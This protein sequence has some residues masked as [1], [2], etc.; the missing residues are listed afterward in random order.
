MRN[1][2]KPLA[3]IIILV[4]A[5]VT[6]AIYTSVEA[7]ESTSVKTV[8]IGVDGMTCEMCAASLE[9]ELKATKGVIDA[10]VSFKK[11]NAWIKYNE[12]QVTVSQL[13]QVI[14]DAGFKPVKKIIN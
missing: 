13:R 12:R 4:L 7:S 2:N 1:K 3:L 10:R 9:P 5:V 6:T 8:T 11:K 14:K